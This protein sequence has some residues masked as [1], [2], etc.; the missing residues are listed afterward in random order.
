MPIDPTPLV[1]S[2]STSA[3]VSPA[4]ASA[5][6]ALSA[7]SCQAVLSGAKRVGCSKAPTT[8][9]RPQMVITPPPTPGGSAS[10]ELRREAPYG[11]GERVRLL[12]R[13]LMAGVRD[14]LEPGA[15]DAARELL[16]APDRRH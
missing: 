4:S 13:R 15:G 10:S 7:C 8:A 3:I 6:R 12:E 9:V 11:V 1:K 5:P 14:D 16:R 2:P